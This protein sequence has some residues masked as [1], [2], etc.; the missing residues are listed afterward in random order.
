MLTTEGKIGSICSIKLGVKKVQSL[1]GSRLQDDN[2]FIDLRLMHCQEVE[3]TIVWTGKADP[4]FITVPGRK[5]CTIQPSVNETGQICFSQTMF[6]DLGITWIPHQ[7]TASE[8]EASVSADNNTTSKWKCKICAKDV[9]VKDMRCHIG[10]HILFGDVTSNYPYGFCGLE[11]CTVRLAYRDKKKRHS[12]VPDECCSYH[13]GTI[14]KAKQ[15]SRRIPCLNYID[16]CPKC[17]TFVWN[18]NLKRHFVDFHPNNN[19]IS[20]VSDS[21][22]EAMKRSKL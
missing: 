4:N 18:Y 7:P 10:R 16:K 22:V 8:M 19:F 20:P 3:E 11:G 2:V 17:G 14:R 5:C 1:Q 6:S 12:Y 13:S 15:P 9:Q 21:E